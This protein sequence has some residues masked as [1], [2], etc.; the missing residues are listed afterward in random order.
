MHLYYHIIPPHKGAGHIVH[1]E[2][3][4]THKHPYKY[5]HEY[6][7]ISV[8]S[9]VLNWG[10]LGVGAAYIYQDHIKLPHQDDAK[11]RLA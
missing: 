10:T 8:S 5:E 1:S 9:C 2:S 3:D 6:P 11:R 7:A 4:K